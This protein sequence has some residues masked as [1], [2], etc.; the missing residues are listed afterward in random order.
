TTQET[1]MS[2]APLSWQYRPTIQP[3][4]IN[5]VATSAKGERVVTGTFFHSYSDARRP[6]LDGSTGR[7]GTYLLGGQGDLLWKDEFDGYEGV[8][9]VAITPAAGFVASCGWYNDSPYQGF[10]FI[11]DANSGQR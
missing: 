10:V 5:S 2:D 6:T 1:P 11:Y 9:W 8:Y 3:Y 4:Y 7:F